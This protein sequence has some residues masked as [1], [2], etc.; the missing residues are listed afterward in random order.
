MYF[1]GPPIQYY[2]DLTI[3][4]PAAVSFPFLIFEAAVEIYGRDT[5][6]Y[7]YYYTY[8]GYNFRPAGTATVISFNLW[9]FDVVFLLYCSEIIGDTVAY[10]RLAYTNRMPISCNYRASINM[11]ALTLKNMK[12]MKICPP[13]A[14]L[15]AKKL[16]H[17]KGQALSYV[18]ISIRIRMPNSLIPLYFYLYIACDSN[19][20]KKWQR[21]LELP[22]ICFYLFFFHYSSDLFIRQLLDLY[23]TYYLPFPFLILPN[24]SEAF[25]LCSLLSMGFRKD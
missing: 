21:S 17:S 14:L 1:L 20:L 6:I 5:G 9:T 3:N 25:F 15:I 24:P 2:P 19:R 18:F 8:A 22:Y 4:L 7:R 12:W 11:R 10:G 16:R 13:I 23:W